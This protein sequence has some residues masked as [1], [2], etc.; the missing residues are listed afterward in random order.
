[1]LTVAGRIES[2]TGGIQF[3]DGTIQTTAATSGITGVTAG[4]GLTGGGASG[5]VPLSIAPGGV[6]TTQ[7]A[8]GAVTGAKISVPLSLIASSS[9]PLVTVTNNS[10]G[11]GV[12]GSSFFGTGI[13]GSSVF[14]YGVSGVSGTFTAVNAVSTSGFGV[15]GVSQTNFGVSGGT[16]STSPGIAAVHGATGTQ[17][18]FF[19][20]KVAGVFGDSGNGA[21]VVGTSNS[22]IGVW[23]FSKSSFGVLGVAATSSGG[24]AGVH[25]TT[26]NVSGFSTSSVSGVWGDSADG[27]G[28]F[29]TS[30]SGTGVSGFSNSTSSV[31]VSGESISGV[32]V[33]G[34][35]ESVA[36]TGSP[37]VYGKANGNDAVWAIS[38]FGNG[39]FAQGGTAA[40]V[41]NGSVSV[42]GNL[43]KG[44]G[45]F[46]IDHPLDPENKYL[47][48]SFVES[49]D[50][51]NIYDGV[52]VLDPNGE[53]TV[54]LPDWFGALNRDFRYLL[55]AVGA[56]G[57]G[58][59]IAEEISGNHF[60]I[61]G[62]GP[63]MKVSWQVTG[64]RQ[65]AYANKHRIPVEEQKSADER[66]CYLHPDAFNQP[67][68][69]N[70]VRVHF[71][72]LTTQ[73]VETKGSAKQE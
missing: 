70:V 24:V 13:A 39:I 46:K 56:P 50:M 32:G 48:H 18:G 9:N 30:S 41:F 43:S 69:K 31:A 14:G 33:L 57:P 36:K 66:G 27:I 23:G 61:A 38:T 64:I 15:N 49:P 40:G 6:G 10:T 51:K 44:G 8:D 1:M 7:L 34:Q 25:G 68:E 22:D 19:Y 16:S 26:N 45:S 37:G 42:S 65:D 53:A 12:A 17:S 55:T 2:T 63:G 54:Q 5:N 28:V 71:P 29:G 52:V 60:K 62:G 3:P 20:A 35:S 59:Y 47:Y 73:P 72:K 58:L 21:G 11:T 67:E 4:T